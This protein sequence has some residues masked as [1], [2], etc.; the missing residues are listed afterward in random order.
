M[1]VMFK[2]EP[3]IMAGKVDALNRVMGWEYLHFK[4]GFMDFW[5]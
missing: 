2:D 5:P 1:W 4:T 3:D